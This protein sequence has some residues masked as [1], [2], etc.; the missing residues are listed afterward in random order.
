MAYGCDA[1]T[2]HYWR[3]PGA[4]VG[5]V[6]NVECEKIIIGWVCPDTGNVYND[7]CWEPC[8]TVYQNKSLVI[9]N[10][11]KKHAGIYS[12]KLNITDLPIEIELI[13]D[14]E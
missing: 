7:D 13:V 5:C 3:A 6:E 12:C 14:G 1:I 9:R 10:V 11:E 4:L 8:M 2:G